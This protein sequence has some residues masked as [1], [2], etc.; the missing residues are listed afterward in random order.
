MNKMKNKIG[1][2]IILLGSLVSCEDFLDLNPENLISDQTFFAN[3][4]DFE[5]AL[6]GAY[7][8]IRGMYSGS[9]IQ[10]LN[11]L[12]SDN[13][14]IVWS[15]PSSN[16]M[17]LEQN[18]VTSTNGI[19]SGAWNTCL[20]TI[21]RCNTILNKIEG[22]EFDQS[23]KDRIKGEAYFLRGLSYFYLVQLFGNVPVTDINFTSPA[24]VAASDLS[25][26]PASQVYIKILSDL[27]SAETLLASG[28]N[29]D[30]TH[31]SRG[32]VK[33]LLGKVYLTQKDYDKA[34]TKLKEV[35]DEKQ[36][37]L[38]ANYKDLFVEG[39]NNRA[40]SIFEIQ[41]VS[42]KS[43]GNNYS[44]LFTPAITSMAI[45]PGNMQGSGRI[46]PTLDLVNAYEPGDL[47][48]NLSVK[49]GIPL[50]NGTTA[51]GRYGLKFIDYTIVDGQDGNVTFTV[52]RYADV[53]L[54]YAEALNEIDQTPLAHDYINPIRDRANLDDLSGL[55][56]DDFRLS[57]ERERRVEFVYEGHRWF[58][59]KR[60]G[61]LQVVLDSYYASKGL[62]FS[63]QDHEWILPIP[64]N[65]I[66]LNPEVII[67]NP[68][69]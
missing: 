44:A 12:S 43:I 26:K 25:L 49:E 51:P 9:A 61:R 40:E 27:T 6:V 57:L 21:S 17:Q 38:A 53:L 15:S 56:Q 45:F 5:T 48:K 65:E 41:F 11:E 34:A 3:Q 28:L 32:T 7:S 62:N 47:R 14:E 20:Y 4:N 24:Q 35:I 52:L 2:L 13:A 54:M 10:Y 30:K 67:Q 55:D 16:E 68:D 18:S 50:I 29:P 22:V 59:L 1:I 39:N 46:L 58:D 64:Q 37:T 60:T 69:Y 19:L 33:T 8:S 31:A 63:V 36:Y 23:A 66:D 42:G